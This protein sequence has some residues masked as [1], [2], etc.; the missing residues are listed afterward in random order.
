MFDESDAPS[1]ESSIG[2]YLYQD[3]KN[4]VQRQR[5]VKE[6]LEKEMLDKMNSSK[7]NKKSRDL[8]IKKIEKD[9]Q[10]ILEFVDDQNT[11]FITYNGLGYVLYFLDVFKIH[12]NEQYLKKIR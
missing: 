2:S 5:L 10:N 4:R 7:V 3:F 11:S 12:Y 1:V 6:T 8:V 9:I